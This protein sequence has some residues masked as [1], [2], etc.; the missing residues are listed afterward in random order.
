MASRIISA[1]KAKDQ[2]AANSSNS[3]EETKDLLNTKLIELGTRLTSLE[4]K[5]D[6]ATKDIHFKCSQDYSPGSYYITYARE[7]REEIR[8]KV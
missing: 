5:L 4:E 2:Q 1:R 6:N 3:L 7:N 8:F